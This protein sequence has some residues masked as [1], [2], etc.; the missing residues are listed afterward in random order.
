MITVR[1]KKRKVLP[2]INTLVCFAL[3]EVPL[4]YSDNGQPSRVIAFADLNDV[5]RARLQIV[6]EKLIQCL[7]TPISKAQSLMEV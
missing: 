3:E 4:R 1:R 5:E 6:Q 7:N 2:E